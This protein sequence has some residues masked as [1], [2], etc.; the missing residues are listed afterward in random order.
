MRVGRLLLA[1]VLAAGTSASQAPHRTR[2][3]LKDGSYQVVMSY[4]VAGSRVQFVSAER[5]GN[6]EEIPLALVDLEATKRWEARHTAI[7]GDATKSAAQAPVLDPEL[8]K[9]EAD[10]AALTPEVAP[11]LR[12]A[13]EDSV[14]ALDTFQGSP[15]LVPLVQSDSDLNQKTAHN[16]LRAAIN[17]L[18]SSHQL[19]QLK[20]E[21]SPV[22][23]HVNEPVLYLKL[24]D[25]GPESGPAITVDTHGASGMNGRDKKV[26]PS[27]YVIVRADVRQDARVLAS[28]NTS[29]LG[30]TKR[31]EDVIETFTSTLPGGHWLKIVPREPLLI[32]EY[33]L[34]EVLGEKDINLGVW[35]FGVHPT[36]PEN[37]DVLRPEKRRPGGLTKRGKND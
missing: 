14:L 30:T 8:L 31:Q 33:A 20:G 6:T 34:M 22:Q 13:V 10:R 17:P 32:G 28:F 1:F 21:K 25:A 36:A 5:G 24:D 29:V 23:M 4:K 9:E 26:A 15:E 19:V 7:D 27:E 11:D 18:A 37:R 2:L 3:I 16:I 35:D 12:L